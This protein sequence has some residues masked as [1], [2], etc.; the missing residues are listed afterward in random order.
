MSWRIEIKPSGEEHYLP[1]DATTRRRIKAAL[2]ELAGAEQLFLHP[3]VHL[4]PVS[5][6]ATI[7]SGAAPGGSFWRR[8]G[9]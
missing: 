7:G 9:I 8:I 2:R 6:S 3:E 1:L 4:S 5:S